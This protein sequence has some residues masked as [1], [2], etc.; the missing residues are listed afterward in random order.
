M[1][2]EIRVPGRSAAETPYDPFE[3]VHDAEDPDG[4]LVVVKAFSER[5]SAFELSDGVSVA[6]VYPT[7]PPTDSVVAVAYQR[8]IERALP[9]WTDLDADSLYDRLRDAGVDVFHYPASRLD[10][11][12]AGNFTETSDGC[13]CENCG[14]TVPDTASWLVHLARECPAGR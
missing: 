12:T 11:Y 7:Y 1:S 6:D 3:R 10:P 14:E 9:S 2:S 4:T 5:A 8:P 13:R